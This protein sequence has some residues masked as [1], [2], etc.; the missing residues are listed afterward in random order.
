[1]NLITL[2]TARNAIKR[3]AEGGNCST[4]LLTDRVNE[5]V[6]RLVRKADHR[7]LQ[8]TMRICTRNNILPCPRGVDKIMAAD[9]NGS[10]VNIYGRFYEFMMSGPGDHLFRTQGVDFGLEDIG[11]RFATSFDMPVT[12]G[13]PLVAYSAEVA[14][15]NVELVI[16]AWDTHGH[17]IRDAGVPGLIVPIQHYL[18]GIEGSISRQFYAGDTRLS[19]P[20]REISRIVKPVT[21]GYVDL[22]CVDVTTSQMWLLGC[23]H[24]D[25]TV[26]AIHRYRITNKSNPTA[27]ETAQVAMSSD[28]VNV[29]A[30]VK[31]GYV[32]LSRDNDVLP[33]DSVDAIKLMSMAIEEENAKN[34]MEAEALEVKAVRLLVESEGSQAV[35]MGGPGYVDRLSMA[36]PSRSH[37]RMIL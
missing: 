33:I 30:L 11:S 20:V 25:D 26:P 28:C 32:P 19:D 5:C 22:Y 16:Q 31:L 10:A 4:A 14:D 7:S 18:G 34:I 23:Y 21:Q 37:R 9:V 15:K 36:M 2:A 35:H 24:P 1:M 8:H 12:T 17:E 3:W 29:L 27:G 6:R 13:L